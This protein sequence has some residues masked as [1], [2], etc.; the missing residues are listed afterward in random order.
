MSDIAIPADT[1][2]PEKFLPLEKE[3]L[4]KQFWMKSRVAIL[5][6]LG[7]VLFLL[8]WE[9]EARYLK[10]V[11][12]FFI[13][14]ISSIAEEGW[15]SIINLDIPKNLIWSFRNF[16]IGYAIA[17]GVAVPL[18]LAMGSFRIVNRLL[19]PYL[20]IGFVM[21]RI[22][23]LPIVIIALGF[24]P[25][26]KIL[27]IFIS[28]FFP[29]ILNTIAGV[30]TVSPSLVKVGRLFGGS[31]VAIY[32]KIILPYAINFVLTGMR[33]AAR[34]G[35]VVMYATEIFGSPAGLGS[36]VVRQSELF[37]MSGAFAG[38]LVLVATSI[39]VLSIFDYLD[40]LF[41]PWKSEVAF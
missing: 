29:I 19:S 41:R 6:L 3:T 31:K 9:I 38:V 2:V 40:N 24:G 23:F 28:C 25:E 22:A 39:T 5:S 35:L 33:I 37:N 34:T 15:K 11:Q 13:P 12:P 21:P 14:P 10:W 1:S 4:L 17:I 30:Q 26:A 32:R 8:F 20:W 36:Y 7:I 16:L 18:G 27:F